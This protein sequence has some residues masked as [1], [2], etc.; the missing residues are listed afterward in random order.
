MFTG[1]GGLA[2]YNM[3]EDVNFLGVALL[4]TPSP[5]ELQSPASGMSS[6][7]AASAL[8]VGSLGGISPGTPDRKLQQSSSPAPTVRRGIAPLLAKDGSK[9]GAAPAAVLAPLGLVGHVSSPEEAVAEAGPAKGG[10]R[11][12][13]SC[14]HSQGAVA[15]TLVTPEKEPEPKQRGHRSGWVI[16]CPAGEAEAAE[17]V[18]E[19]AG[20]AVA[21]VQPKKRGRRSGRVISCPAGEAEAAEEAV[22]EEAG[23][24]AA[25]AAV[26]EGRPEKRR[27]RSGQATSQ[28]AE[29]AEEA[30]A[31]PEEAEGTVAEVRPK[32]RARVKHSQLTS[33]PA[34][35]VEAEELA[36]EDFS[37]RVDW[38]AVGKL[39]TFAGRY[40]PNSKA[41][42]LTWMTRRFLF[43][44]QVPQEY[45]T[46]ISQRSFWKYLDDKLQ[47]GGTSEPE[48]ARQF[49]Q[50]GLAGAAAE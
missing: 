47:G 19:E 36:R 27:H 43:Y 38:H 49:V 1:A 45:H 22:A 16:S 39:K 35:G 40:A 21:E 34:I 25:G 33:S 7:A 6:P 18:A 48:A 8:S 12:G 30:K 9:P 5:A 3:P 20:A 23:A 4:Y 44:S 11:G 50:E 2:D 17:A 14:K 28:P 46:T 10:G 24:A 15:E 29:E 32:S 26:A 41:G 31:V 42:L 13:R 37:P